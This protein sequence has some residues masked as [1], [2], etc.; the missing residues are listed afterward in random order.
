MATT[1]ILTIGE[2]CKKRLELGPMMRE[3][4]FAEALIEAERFGYRLPTPE[5]LHALYALGHG[6][7]WPRNGV[8]A[9]SREVRHDTEYTRPYIASEDSYEFCYNEDRTGFGGGSTKYYLTFLDGYKVSDN[10]TCCVL[11]VRDVE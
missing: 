11:V 7:P 1:R 3:M 5:E 6:K 8:W 10:K 9:T 2:H 4:T